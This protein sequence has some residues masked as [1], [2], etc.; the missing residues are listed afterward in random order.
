M[1][2]TKSAESNILQG[3]KCID[4]NCKDLSYT[5]TINKSNILALYVVSYIP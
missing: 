3:D 1:E 4:I 2:Q 5:L